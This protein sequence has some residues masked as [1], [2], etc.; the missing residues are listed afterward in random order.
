MKKFVVAPALAALAMFVLGAAFWMSPF[1]YR[2]LTPVADN[3]AAGLALAQL[4]P[5]TGTYL[6]PGPE[7]KDQALLTELYRRGPSAEVQFIKEGHNPMEAGVFVRGYVHYF[8]V[9]L[10]LAVLLDRVRIVRTGYGARVR[11]VTLVGVIAAVF[12]CFSDAIWWHHPWGWHLMSAL[13]TMLAFL[14]AGLVLAR[15]FRNNDAVP[16]SV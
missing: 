8:F 11:F 14:A 7:I 16:V 1:P 13:Y 9:A 12:V 4:F 15:F 5:T 2:A 6:I 3:S 10:L